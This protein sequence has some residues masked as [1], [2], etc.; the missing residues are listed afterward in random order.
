MSKCSQSKS[1]VAKILVDVHLNR[2][3]WFHFFILKEGSLV[4]PVV[5]VAFLIPFL[6]VIK[7]SLLI[8]CF[9]LQLDSRTLDLQNA[10]F[11]LMTWMALSLKLRGTFWISYTLLSLSFSSNYMSRGGYLALCVG[12]PSKIKGWVQSQ[13]KVFRSLFWF[14]YFPFCR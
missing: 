12:N 4:I 14:I 3:I 6:S 1:S 5:C 10:F 11:S 7:M 8:V 2:L 13:N 9:L